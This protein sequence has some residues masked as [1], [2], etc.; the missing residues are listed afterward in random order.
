[1][2]NYV[3]CL[4]DN[5]HHASSRN[6]VASLLSVDFTELP[7]HV[8]PFHQFL[9]YTNEQFLFEVVKHENRFF[10]FSLHN[11]LNVYQ[12]HYNPAHNVS[13]PEWRSRI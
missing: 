9:L 2:K 5:V 8:P 3:H 10:K 7:P 13:A 11:F 4:R 6:C 1:M 12:E